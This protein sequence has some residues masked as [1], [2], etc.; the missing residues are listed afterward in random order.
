MDWWLT[1]EILISQTT[2]SES[3]GHR[4]W[5]ILVLKLLKTI[6]NVKSYEMSYNSTYSVSLVVT[7]NEANEVR[8]T[9]KFQT[10][11][12][13]NSFSDVTLKRKMNRATR[14]VA[15]TALRRHESALHDGH[16][17]DKIPLRKSETTKSAISLFRS[18]IRSKTVQQ[19][20][21]RPLLP[22]Y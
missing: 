17:P 1:C 10:F 7:W 16:I 15:I 5:W 21:K 8:W 13:M 4:G 11:H 14:V 2:C 3:P 6:E 20:R 12:E 22:Q 19:K 9:K 18:S